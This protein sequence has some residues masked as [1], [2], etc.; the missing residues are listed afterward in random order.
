[1]FVQ[2]SAAPMRHCQ[3]G[4]GLVPPRDLPSV[5]VPRE[6]HRDVSLGCMIKGLWVVREHEVYTLIADGGID[7]LFA[8]SGRSGPPDAANAESI[9]AACDERH[10]VMQHGG[11]SRGDHSPDILSRIEFVMIAQHEEVA[12]W[13]VDGGKGIGHGLDAFPVQVHEIS[14]VAHHVRF[15]SS[16]LRDNFEGP[17]YVHQ[18]A[19]MQIADVADADAIKGLRPSGRHDFLL[20]NI[21]ALGVMS[22][23]QPPTAEPIRSCRQQKVPNTCLTVLDGAFFTRASH[24]W[25]RAEKRVRKPERKRVAAGSLPVIR[26]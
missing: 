1:M 10:I 22:S 19:H 24:G 17:A 21:N 23:I 16:E 5:C 3:V 13:R 2:A 11:S 26:N 9:F 6:H 4:I 25:V 14:R 20:N 12:Q 18:D 7:A 8:S 15:G